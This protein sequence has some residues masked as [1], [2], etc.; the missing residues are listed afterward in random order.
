ME[1]QEMGFTLEAGRD[2]VLDEAIPQQES[3][4][5]AADVRHGANGALHLLVQ[6]LRLRSPVFAFR[7]LLDIRQL[8]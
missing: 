1:D 7:K 8:T 5:A 2:R 3:D 6:Q 4:I